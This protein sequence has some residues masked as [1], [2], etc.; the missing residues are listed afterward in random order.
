MDLARSEAMKSA[1]VLMRSDA[2][3][4]QARDC[5]SL[6]AALPTE[7][8]K[9][10]I[11]VSEDAAL[12]EEFQREERPALS[13]DERMLRDQVKRTRK[14]R[15]VGAANADERTVREQPLPP[16]ATLFEANFKRKGPSNDR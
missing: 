14:L 3:S 16:L 6:A 13:V 11:D 1:R 10:N 4:R 5:R 2:L 12:T 15:W 7:A 8:S 9:G